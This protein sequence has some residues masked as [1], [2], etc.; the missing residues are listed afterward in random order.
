MTKR[1]WVLMLVFLLI[2][3]GCSSATIEE[4]PDTV[5]DSFE[6]CV[7]EESKLVETAASERP[8]T[9]LHQ[10]ELNDSTVESEAADVSVTATCRENPDPEPVTESLES[11]IPREIEVSEAPHEEAVSIADPES[12]SFQEVESPSN[13]EQDHEGPEETIP[14]GSAVPDP[15]QESVEPEPEPVIPEEDLEPE[16]VPAFDIGYWI[17]YAK[18]LA[19]SKGLKLDASATDCWDNPI[20][21]NPDCIYLERDLNSRLSRYANDEEIAD[22]WIWYEDLGNQHYLIYI[23]YA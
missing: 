15:G 21:A 12:S 6:V 14:E 10:I 11:E 23:G 9:A 19:E 13:G 16:P 2:L 8:E 4:Q 5:S 7:S 3:S 17:N 18:S 20:T 22:V 1:V